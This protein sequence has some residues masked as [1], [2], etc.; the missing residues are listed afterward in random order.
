MTFPLVITVVDL[1]ISLFVLVLS[2]FVFR[3]DPA[4]KI[5]QLYGLT[6]LAFAAWI[7]S[8][9]LSDITGFYG[10][11]FGA[12]F[13]AR[14]AIVGPFWLCPLFLYF[15]YYFPRVSGEMNRWK[16]LAI[17]AI[18][19]IAMFFVPTGYNVGEIMLES[20]GTNFTPGILY[21]VLFLCL[22][23]FLGTA[24]YR[25]GR[26]YRASLN[27]QEKAQIFYVFSGMLAFLI[28]G[29][30]TNLILPLV[31]GI[32]WLSVFGPS[33][34]MLI[35]GTLTSY[36]ILKHHLLETWIV[37][38]MGTIFAILFAIIAFVYVF[39]ASFL[40]RYIG[41]VAPLLIMPL[42]I[43]LTFEPLK[44]FIEDKTDKIFFSK[45]YKV[46]EVIDELTSTVYKS[47]L[48][49]GKILSAFN[50]IVKR[51]FKVAKATVAVLTPKETFLADPAVDGVREDFELSFD[52]PLVEFLSVNSG[53][54]LNRDEI[55]Q[56][57]NRGE[58][59]LEAD[60]IDLAPAAYEELVRLDFV[61][62]IPI[63]SAEKL[64]AI[65]F[66]GSKKSNDFFDHQDLQLL[67]HL[68]GEAGALINNAR[69]YEDLKKLDEAKSNFISVVSHQLRTPLSAMRW[70]TELLLDGA[71]DKS[72]EREFLK[73]TYK[74]SIFMIYHLDDMLTALDVEDKEI[75]LKKEVCALRQFIDEVLKENDAVIKSKKLD[76]K[77]VIAKEAGSIYCDPKKVKKVFEVMIANALHYS[78]DAGGKI[79]IT[80]RK[81]A[82]G[83]R[84]FLEISVADNGLGISSEEQKYIFEKFYRGEEAKKTSPN[85]FGLGLFIIRAFARAHDGDAHFESAGRNKGAKFYF[86]LAMHD[87]H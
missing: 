77:V 37:A 62:A 14:A 7:I 41:G 58:M 86:T 1:T 6:I 47:G 55:L 24:L 9:S 65:Y 59:R 82:D 87:K 31:W 27:S 44:K 25:L 17:F 11:E 32:A 23:G 38:R 84:E 3:Q 60:R 19:A 4:R 16:R 64:I 52:N 49:L 48:D 40:S 12:L 22:F 43:V 85:G 54:I 2:L 80:G 5:N 75:E 29:P 71:V 30:T 45:H 50:E 66:I 78:P 42:L 53:F 63:T 83:D 72:S 51:N 61:L 73:D 10:S 26:S 70:T 81:K 33:L 15:T 56:N 76:I 20:W 8:S 69:L 21:P 67:V 36:A 13:W 39:F 18:P 57:L 35:F 68:T 34:A 28:I 46:D 74:N 79:E